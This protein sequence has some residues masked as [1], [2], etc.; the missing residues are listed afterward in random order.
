MAGV[1]CDCPDRVDSRVVL[2]TGANSGIGLQVARELALR[3]TS[4]SLSATFCNDIVFLFCN[5]SAQPMHD[6][7]DD[8]L[9]C[10]SILDGWIEYDYVSGAEGS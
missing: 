5:L 9:H 3:G 7:E 6:K 4:L 10:L 8:I 2:V 1:A